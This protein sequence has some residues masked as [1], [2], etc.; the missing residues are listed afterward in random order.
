MLTPP[1]DMDEKH[2]GTFDI[3]TAMEVIEH[4]K[5]KEVFVR[6]LGR[7]LKP[8][9]TIFLSSIDKTIESNLKLI[10]SA[11]YITRIVPIGTHDIE[12][13][14]SAADLGVLLR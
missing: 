12:L 2:F 10:V 5:N 7:L 6:A 11:E 4:V 9:G 3:I 8:G 1:E 14:I 13:F